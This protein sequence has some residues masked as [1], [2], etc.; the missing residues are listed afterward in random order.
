MG[1]VTVIV[2]SFGQMEKGVKA[3]QQY[4]Y[5]PAERLGERV[6]PEETGEWPESEVVGVAKWQIIRTIW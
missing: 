5:S 3:L 6:W 4:E 1:F 2:L